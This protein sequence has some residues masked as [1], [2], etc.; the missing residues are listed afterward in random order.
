LFPGEALVPS[1][2]YKDSIWALN[3]RTMLL[4]LACVRM[5]HD[6]Q[7][8]DSEKADF[9]MAAWLEVD[10]LEEALN[11]HTCGLERAFLFQGREYLFK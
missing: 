4:W 1:H 9:G 10:A 5:R 7:A 11:N 8:T 3:Y 2:H 6:F